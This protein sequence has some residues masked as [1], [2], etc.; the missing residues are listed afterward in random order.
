MSEL[1]EYSSENSDYQISGEESLADINKLKPYDLETMISGESEEDQISTDY[2]DNTSEE[3]RQIIFNV[4]L[5]KCAW[6]METNVY[7]QE[8]NVYMAGNQ[9]LH[10]PNVCVVKRRMKLVKG[11]LRF[12]KKKF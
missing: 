9:C 11:K 1:E 8:T 2:D 6:D 4:N 12:A 7:I 5:C 3:K 10:T